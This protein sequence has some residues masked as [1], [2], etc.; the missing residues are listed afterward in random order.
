MAG[1][2][3]PRGGPTHTADF[4]LW[5]DPD[6]ADVV[7]AANLGTGLVPLDLTRQV[8]VTAREVQRCASSRDPLVRWLSEA[9]RFSVER[10][11]DGSRQGGAVHDAV[12]VAAAL[13]PAV[14]AF[15]ARRLK[16]GGRN[17]DQ[18]GSCITDA[19]GHAVEIATQ[20]DVP[21]VRQILGRV[22]PI[23]TE[24]GGE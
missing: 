15:E 19:A 3:R 17:T 16:I 6:A 21:R 7:L 10:T 14:L 20:I 8:R 18:R 5:A 24:S 2:V 22:L 12:V 1:A 13:E 9:L 11:P 4:N 23:E